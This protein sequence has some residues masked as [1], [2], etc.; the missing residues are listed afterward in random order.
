MAIT[1]KSHDRPLGYSSE[2]DDRL[3]LAV[4]GED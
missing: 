3:P 2:D 1:E 4:P